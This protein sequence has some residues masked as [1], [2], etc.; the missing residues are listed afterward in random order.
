M[1]GCHTPGMVE[2]V[3][4]GL[5]GALVA[6]IGTVL[7]IRD[8]RRGRE[9]AVEEKAAAALLAQLRRVRLE[10][11]PLNSV[12]AYTVFAEECLTHILSFRDARVRR[13]LTGSVDIIARMR[14]VATELVPNAEW[15]SDDAVEAAFRDVRLVLEARLD[16]RR[17]LPKP[18]RVWTEASRDTVAYLGGLLERWEE[19]E[20][21][22][23]QE[24]E[25]REHRWAVQADYEPARPSD[26]TG[27]GGAPAP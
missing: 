12:Q 19:V 18:E 6:L 22:E 1:T 2:A 8:T 25:E 11:V 7:V 16:R 4:G 3:I 14:Y 10:E 21:E 17:R 15:L 23:E 24:R 20:A 27:P 26:A 5:V 13:R 9:A